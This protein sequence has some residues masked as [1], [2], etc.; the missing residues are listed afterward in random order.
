VQQLGVRFSVGDAWAGVPGASQAFCD[1][2]GTD[3]PTIRRQSCPGEEGRSCAIAAGLFGAGAGG[4]QELAAAWKQ[5]E[6]S[7][8]GV[9]YGYASG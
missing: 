1:G 3:L 5:H 9:I 4:G 8:W 7:L 6:T 2:D